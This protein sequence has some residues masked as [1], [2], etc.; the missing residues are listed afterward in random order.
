MRIRWW[1]APGIA[2]AAALLAACGSSSASGSGSGTASSTSAP[3]AASSAPAAA[4]TP[5]TSAVGLKTA[6]T[7][8]GT[9]L[10]TAQGYAVYMFAIDTPTKSNCDATCLKV[11]PALTGMPSAAAGSGLTGKLG[12]ITRTGGIPQATYPGHPLYLFADDKAP[13]QV[14]GNGINTSGGLWYA[15]TPSGA[16][17]V[18]AAKPAASATSGSTG[19]YGYCPARRNGAPGH[20]DR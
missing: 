6:K 7:A 15:L 18:S 10:V 2:A 1:A 13:G 9:V 5:S 20:L 16:K 12:P 14:N 17:L 11:S 3:A 19:G 4:A 8:K